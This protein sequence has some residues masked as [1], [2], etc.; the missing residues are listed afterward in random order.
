MTS[1]MCCTLISPTPYGV[2]TTGSPHDMPSSTL[3][4]IPE[5]EIIGATETLDVDKSSAIES[6]YPVT[7][8]FL[9]ANFLI[10]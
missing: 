5:P 9:D 7:I 8:I 2:V 3:N 10:W 1:L 6:T 4:C